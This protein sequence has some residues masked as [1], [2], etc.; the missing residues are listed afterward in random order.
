MEKKII[1]IYLCM[2][3]QTIR[4]MDEFHPSFLFLSIFFTIHPLYQT[5]KFGLINI[6]LVLY[7]LERE[8]DNQILMG[9]IAL[10]KPWCF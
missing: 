4:W 9:G 5:E 3:H 7:Y 1:L 2:F 8:T 10:D 6:V